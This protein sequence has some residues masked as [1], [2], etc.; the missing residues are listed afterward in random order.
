MRLLF[1]RNDHT[2]ADAF[3]DVLV[4]DAVKHSYDGINIDFEAY[5]NLTDPSSPPL[6]QDGIDFA[7]FL[8]RFAEQC[9][10][11]GVALSV[12]TDTPAGECESRA[13]PGEN[14]NH[15]QP[16]PWYT[17]LYNWDSLAVAGIDKVIT[18]ST[19][20]WGEISFM[21]HVLWMTWFIK[22]DNAGI[23]L[24]PWCLAHAKVTP[25]QAQL[26]YRFDAIS[27]FG[28]NE[29]DVWMLGPDPQL[30]AALDSWN[31]FFAD[32]LAAGGY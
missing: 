13:N 24:C 21:N 31:P 15:G 7:A 23:G 8:S 27:Q 20:T 32:F 22:R 9:H 25:T 12:D 5:G 19:Y 29:I 30:L 11:V 4:G 6:L 1:D 10:K 16:C 26:Q 28:F 14:R 3:I 17:R 18:M 2:I